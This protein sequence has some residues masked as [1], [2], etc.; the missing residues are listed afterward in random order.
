M[1]LNRAQEPYNWLQNF[2]RLPLPFFHT[3]YITPETLTYLYY[4]Q[5]INTC[6]LTKTNVRTFDNVTYPYVKEDTCWTLVAAD[7]VENPTF[8]VFMKKDERTKQLV[9][10]VMVGDTKVEFIPINEK[11]FQLFLKGN[12][13]KLGPIELKNNEFLYVN[14]RKLNEPNKLDTDYI[15]RILRKDRKFVLDF[16]PQI[17]LNFDGNSVNVVAGP[18]LR[19]RNCGMCG[20]YNRVKANELKDT[21]MCVLKNGEEM[22]RAWTLKNE[23]NSQIDNKPSCDMPFPDRILY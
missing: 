1:N 4:N 8:A 21:K 6:T 2:F 7:C 22:A 9:L 15:F 5:I 16:Y 12:V 13:G 20:D 18:L 3:S 17:I 10:R 11:E 14:D 19:G 23:C